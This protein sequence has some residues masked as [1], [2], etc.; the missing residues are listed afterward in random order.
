MLPEGARKRTLESSLGELLQ[1]LFGQRML[2]FDGPAARAYADI[3][4][5][6]WRSNYEG[7]GTECPS[8]K[9]CSHGAPW[10]LSL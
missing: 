3:K 5:R 8:H 1:R 9:N 6:A 10:R 2:A 4:S 7:R